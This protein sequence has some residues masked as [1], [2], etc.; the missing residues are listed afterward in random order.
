MWER[1]AP[2]TR[3]AISLAARRMSALC[4]AMLAL[5]LSGQPARQK[6]ISQG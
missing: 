5:I 3:L 2:L 1:P 6:R 4:A